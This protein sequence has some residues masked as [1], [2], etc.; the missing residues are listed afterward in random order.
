MRLDAEL[1]LPPRGQAVHEAGTDDGMALE[2][3]SQSF[4]KSV[5][6]SDVDRRG[7][8]LNGCEFVIVQCE[9]HAAFPRARAGARA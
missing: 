5:A 4:Q 2:L 8:G 7:C 6:V 1:S 9:R 3:I